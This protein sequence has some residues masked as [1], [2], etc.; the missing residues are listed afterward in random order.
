[1]IADLKRQYEERW[2]YPP[3][4]P[5]SKVKM[6]A[7]GE[8]PFYRYQDPTQ[9]S[10]CW[11]HPIKVPLQAQFGVCWEYPPERYRRRPLPPPCRGSTIPI[12]LLNPTF[13]RCENTYTIY[14]FKLEQCVHGQILVVDQK[15]RKLKEKLAKAKPW[16]IEKVKEMRYHGVRYRILAGATGCTKIYPEYLSRMTEERELCEFQRAYNC[17]NQSN[18]D[19]TKLFLDMRESK[20]ELDLRL[21]RLDRSLKSPFLKDLEVVEQMIE[22]LNTYFFGVIVKLK[23]WAELMDPMKEHSIE[24]YLALLSREC[25]F[26]SFM[27]AGLENCTCKRCDKKDPLKPYL[28]CWCQPSQSSED[29]NKA[30]KFVDDCPKIWQSDSDLVNVFSDTSMLVEAAEEKARIAAEKAKV[31]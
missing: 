29:V 7:C 23:T 19:L 2:H 6:V 15:L 30:K 26:K 31:P 18:S 11:Q 10:P 14:D 8:V 1:M 9:Y 4:L 16:Q 12:H 20:K 24:D 17:V 28:P 27:R 13:K 5:P 21:T 3:K 22:D 25:D